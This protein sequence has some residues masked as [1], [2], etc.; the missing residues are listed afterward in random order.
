VA[1][2]VDGTRFDRWL[3]RLVTLAVI[4]A[5]LVGGSALIVSLML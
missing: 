4:T 5:L 2:R 3:D 1:R